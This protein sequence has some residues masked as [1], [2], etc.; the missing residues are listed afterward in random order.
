MDTS[1]H[2]AVL[3]ISCLT[4]SVLHCPLLNLLACQV[5]CEAPVAMVTMLYGY[6]THL[7]GAMAVRSLEDDHKVSFTPIQL[8]RI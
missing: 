1:G 3:F 4:H 2:K 8:G 6:P 7:S 5:M